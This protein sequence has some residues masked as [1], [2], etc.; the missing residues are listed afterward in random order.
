[1]H[2]RGEL[3][4]DFEPLGETIVYHAP[5]QQ[6][7]HGIGKPALTLLGLIPEV[8]I[9]D[10]GATCCGVAGTYGL[11]REKFQIAMD[12]G[13]PLFQQIAETRSG[14]TVCDSETC[15]WHIEHATGVQAVHPIELLYRAS[16]LDQPHPTGGRSA[17]TRRRARRARR[18]QAAS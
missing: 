6:Q 11:K 8:Q 14:M 1:M 15:R 2:D 4:T 10:S 16:G 18:A 9:H 12:V 5:C 13:A 7:G 17:T 3:N